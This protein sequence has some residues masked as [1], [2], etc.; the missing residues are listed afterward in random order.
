MIHTGLTLTDA[1]SLYRRWTETNVTGILIDWMPKFYTIGRVINNF[2]PYF[3]TK[4]RAK[5]FKKIKT[6]VGCIYS[7]LLNN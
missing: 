2:D 5:L 4:P 7:V 6:T 1:I 3:L